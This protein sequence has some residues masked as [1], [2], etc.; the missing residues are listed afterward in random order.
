MH[1]REDGMHHTTEGRNGRGRDG[2]RRK[3]G[4]EL[5]GCWEMLQ[6]PRHTP[7]IAS[8]AANALSTSLRHVLVLV[9]DIRVG[10]QRERADGDLDGLLREVACQCLYLSRPGGAPQQSL[11]VGSNLTENGADLWLE[12]HIQHTIGLIQHQVRH[13]LEVGSCT[14]QHNK[15]ED[16]LHCQYE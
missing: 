16:P 3:K 10:R 12:T 5:P 2:E 1:E 7:T 13:T 4:R 15:R 8:I 11:S 9:T 6:I 14:T